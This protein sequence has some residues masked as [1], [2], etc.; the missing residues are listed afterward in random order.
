MDN[1]LIFD[2]VVI[3]FQYNDATQTYNISISDEIKQSSVY[4]SLSE[5]QFGELIG[6]FKMLESNKF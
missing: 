2:E 5:Y 6:S 4:M 3:Q 1:E